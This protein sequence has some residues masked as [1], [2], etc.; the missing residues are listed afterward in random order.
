MMIMSHTGLFEVFYKSDVKFHKPQN[1][2]L[3]LW[4]PPIQSQTLYKWRKFKTI[5]TLPRSHQPTKITA[6][7]RHVM[8]C[9]VTKKSTVTTKQ[10]MAFITLANVNVHKPKIRRILNNSTVHGWFV[11][12]KPLLSK[13]TLLPVCSLLKNTWTCQKAVGTMICG[14]MTPKTL[15][16]FGFNRKLLEKQQHYIPAKKKF[17]L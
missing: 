15:D 12:R 11:S 7:A 2:F 8:V 10:I 5:I 14:Q 1:H 9:E 4:T 6:R 13:R 16:L 3:S 17:H